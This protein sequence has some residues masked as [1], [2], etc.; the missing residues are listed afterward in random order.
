MR[1]LT[2]YVLFEFL[3]IFLVALTAMTTIVILAVVG[4]EAVRQGLNPANVV[5]LIPYALPM[6]L[7]F[8]IPGTTLFAACS[9]YGR[10]AS[11]NEV[12]AI[13]SMGVSP[14]TLVWPVLTL[15]FLLSLLV[16]GLND[17]A[18]TWGRDGVKRV[19]LESLEQIA[20]GM[21]RTNRSYSGERFSINVSGVDGHKLLGVTLTFHEPGSGQT[22]VF[23][24]EE[25]EMHSNPAADSL[26]VTMTNWEV[27][28]GD[29]RRL[30]DPDRRVIDIP[31]TDGEDDEL[32][33]RRPSD[34]ALRW[35]EEEIQNQRLVIADQQ[36]KFAA[37]A[38]QQLLLGDFSGLTEPVWEQRLASVGGSQARLHRL[39]TEPWRRWATGF[40]CLAFV[41]VGA[42]LAIQLR[43]ADVWTSFAVCFLPI[44][45]IYYP[46]L[47]FGVDRAK[48]GELPACSVWIGNAVL[49]LAG[50]WLLRKV[51]R[52]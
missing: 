28:T 36:Q 32:G 15:S 51:V 24:A 44:L 1:R 45:T 2:R 3:S 13:K 40:S 6:A 23:M 9:I 38:A 37:E 12:I 31:L 29:N 21:L 19:V 39:I 11:S 34:V 22:V 48:S 42:P 52:S 5:R 30:I 43:N 16:V 35:I 46:L 25:A 41:M 18:V 26:S 27:E 10:M 7:V 17:V 8:A 50:W 49:A 47:A 20:Y 14:L 4:Q 33:K